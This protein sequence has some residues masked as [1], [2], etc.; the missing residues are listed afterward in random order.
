MILRALAAALLLTPAARAAQCVAPGSVS[1][2]LDQAE[3]MS[4]Q[5]RAGLDLAAFLTPAIYAR[6]CRAV[7]GGAD[8][9]A[10]FAGFSL[11]IPGARSLE[12][13]CRHR[14]AEAEFSRALVR[15]DDR[16]PELCAAMLLG[17]MGVSDAVKAR[18][19]CTG[20]TRAGS[21]G[22]PD[23]CRALLTAEGR[24]ATDF[25]LQ[26]CLGALKMYRGEVKDCEALSRQDYLAADLPLC[27]AVRGLRADDCA[28]DPLCR[29]LK[30]EG[31]AACDA[32]DEQAKKVF[33]SRRTVPD[34][35]APV[36]GA[37][38]APKLSYADDVLPQLPNF[39]G[40]PK[41]PTDE[42]VRL[43]GDF[44]AAKRTSYP[45]FTNGELLLPQSYAEGT[46]YAAVD[47]QALS[48]LLRTAHHLADVNI[49]YDEGYRPWHAL[50]TGSEV[51]FLKENRAL[52]EPS[53]LLYT[54]DAKSGRYQLVRI[55]YRMGISKGM[56]P[57]PP[58]SASGS[59]WSI[60]EHEP[61][62]ILN[63]A[64]PVYN[65]AGL[66]APSFADAGHL[67]GTGVRSFFGEPVPAPRRARPLCHP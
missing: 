17:Q 50:D 20:V 58:F 6:A 4:P 59:K 35:H 14:L 9:C 25:R 22:D 32:Y 65:I 37:Q 19:L 2:L 13:N 62:L 30:G 49:A 3:A 56:T 52:D 11:R 8:A 64:L 45:T 55:G 29:A 33:A 18:T 57:P 67:A 61:K 28:G 40:A 34:E 39:P 66:F 5:E 7:A 60:E 63:V 38:G 48:K 26:G 46:D 36:A 42:H 54:I 53:F 23:L 31:A 1:A 15:R 12:W 47:R 21:A 44:P 24:E 43:F 51:A 27:H 41:L 10:E 16:A